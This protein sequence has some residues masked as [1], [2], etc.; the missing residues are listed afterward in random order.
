MITR[1]SVVAVHVS[2]QDKALGFYTD[3]LGFEKRSDEPME[4]GARWIEVAPAGSETSIFL[5]PASTEG[6]AGTWANII[7]ECD[8]IH[9]THKELRSRGVQFSE[10]PS[11]QPWGMW[12]R[13][14][15]QDGN[16]FGLYSS[17]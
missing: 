4:D 7:F 5:E 10:E 3:A 15:D 1:A 11:E 2:D 16:E 14:K 17:R 8:D 12:A 13:F 9:A 6:R